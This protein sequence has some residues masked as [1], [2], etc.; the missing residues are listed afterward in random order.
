MKRSLHTHFRLSVWISLLAV[1]DLSHSRGSDLPDYVATMDK[2]TTQI[3]RLSTREVKKNLLTG[4]DGGGTLSAF[5]HE[6][7][8]RHLK[9][10]IGMSNRQVENNYYYE[11]DQLVFASSKQSF[12]LWDEN[13][14]KLNPGKVTMTFEDAYYFVEGKLRHWNTNR[15]A[16]D[17]SNQHSNVSKESE[18]V[19]QE[20]SF[21][22]QT[23]RDEKDSVSIE[24][25]IRR[26]V[27]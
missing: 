8:I 18:T 14:Q 20:S 27:R 15:A 3:D 25:F 10:T 24:G 1:F 19:L 23:A 16:A 5:W 6:G 26:G 13:A 11:N 21:F 12:F 2:K 17:L 9:I 22:M 4:T 7:Q